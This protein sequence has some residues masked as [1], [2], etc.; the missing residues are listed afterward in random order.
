MEG[1]HPREASH[2]GDLDVAVRVLP[3]VDA[4]DRCAGRRLLP[5]TED[6]GHV[7][8]VVVVGRRSPEV[9]AGAALQQV[10]AGGPVRQHRPCAQV[11]VQLEVRG[12]AAQ[13][14]DVAFRPSHDLGGLG[15]V[16]VPALRGRSLKLGLRHDVARRKRSACSRQHDVD[17]PHVREDLP[18]IRLRHLGVVHVHADADQAD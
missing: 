12:L 9:G 2:D 6:A 11:E 18:T 16:D 17:V 4:L 10:P 3:P 5:R 1:L 14:E 13:P 8:T 7:P 15:L